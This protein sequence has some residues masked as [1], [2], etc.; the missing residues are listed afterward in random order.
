[1]MLSDV[2]G[3]PPKFCLREGWIAIREENNTYQN[4]AEL[5]IF[6]NAEP[7]I[8]ETYYNIAKLN[9][10]EKTEMLDFAYREFEKLRIK[11]GFYEKQRR[12]EKI[13]EEVAIPSEETMKLL[14]SPNFFTVCVSEVS[15]KVAG[16]ER[17]I[18]TIALFA[19]GRLVENSEASSFNFALNDES[20]VGKDY[21][22]RNALALFIPHQDFVYRSRITPAALTYMHNPKYEPEWTWN[23]KFLFLE[24]V[25]D[26]VLNCEVVKTFL[27]GG[28]FATV[29]FQQRTV[30]IEIKGK[31]AIGLTF[32]NST[33]KNETLRRLQLVSM[34]SSQKQTARIK[35]F[36]KRLA[37]SGQSENY[38]KEILSAIALLERVKVIIPEK[39]TNSID[40]F[41]DDKIVRTN[42]GRFFDLIKASAAFHQF[43]RQK[44]EAGFV[45]ATG[46]D[47]E[48][49]A[50]IFCSLVVSQNMIP[51][52]KNQQRLLTVIREME[53]SNESKKAFSAPEIES[54]VTFL[55]RPNLYSNLNDLS[56]S[57]HLVK[58][59]ESRNTSGSEHF[60]RMAE[61]TVYSFK[62][63][64]EFTLPS[65]QKL[66]ERGNENAKNA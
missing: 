21:V 13:E 45:I 33:L 66:Q 20:G 46:E 5:S 12:L 57:G 48:L 4:I 1:M 3:T 19:A 40:F 55:A 25:S 2:S 65:H 39:I 52:S 23:G 7:K 14:Q 30:D 9:E 63:Q 38:S 51:V 22:A 16:E 15:K 31:P 58:S 10:F 17:T 41:P 43:Q 64:N 37:Q 42:S 24:D 54:R 60:A 49:A 44:N 8:K 62:N 53:K 11:T 36:K 56:D 28:S 59:V 50:E 32:A 61:V 34:D 27:T 18:Q 6:L 29:V 35:I 47:Y 26:N